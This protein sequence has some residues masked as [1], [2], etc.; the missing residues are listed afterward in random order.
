MAATSNARW[1]APPRVAAVIPARDEAAVIASVVRDLLA[2]RSDGHAL[3][4]QVMVCDNGSRDGTGA[5]A[6]RAGA[7]VV[8]E[9]QAGY[10]AACLAA[11]GALAPCDIVVFVDGDGSMDPA[12]VRAVIAAVADGADLAIGWRP[13][14]WIE[15]GAMT[16]P[17][18]IGNVVAVSLIGILFGHRFHDLGPLRALRAAMLPDLAMSDRAFGWTV[19]MQVKAILCGH[20]VTE[21]PVHVRRRVGRSKISGTLRGVVGAGVGIIG[22]IVALRFNDWNGRWRAWRNAKDGA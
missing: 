9:E 15:P 2:L 18:R 19:E 4:E 11:L 21:L 14:A 22:K 20:R 13:N 10:G 7:S 17:Q 6:I 3:I 1:Y 5:E 8:R 16:W 12:D